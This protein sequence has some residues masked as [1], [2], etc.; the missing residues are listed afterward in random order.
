M[1]FAACGIPHHVRVTQYYILL[2]PVLYVAVLLVESTF[3]FVNVLA[4]VRFHFAIAPPIVTIVAS[5]LQRRFRDCYFLLVLVVVGLVLVA[6]D[7]RVSFVD[8]NNFQSTIVPFPP[9]PYPTIPNVVAAFAR[10]HVASFEAA[11]VHP[12]TDRLYVLL[13]FQ[14]LSL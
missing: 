1:S 7:V 9:R 6:V 13:L 4:I 14:C 10:M 2:V 3:P 12:R 8:N 5:F 11:A